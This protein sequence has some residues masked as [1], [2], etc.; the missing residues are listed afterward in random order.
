MERGPYAPPKSQVRDVVEVPAGGLVY[1][2][3]WRRFGAYW[4]DFLVLLP[5]MGIGYY[6]GEQSRLFQVYW[7]IPGL[8]IGLWFH[9][10]L[11]RRYGGTPGKLLLSTRIAM[12]DGS[13]VT[14]NAAALRYSVLFVLSTAAS[15]AI[16]LAALRMG[17]DEYFS[18]AYLARVQ[19][20]VELAP[21]WY[22]PVNILLQIWVWSEFVT[23][24]FN[25]KRRAIHDFMAGTVV[26]RTRRPERLPE[27]VPAHTGIA[28]SP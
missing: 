26:I 10:D 25:K 22:Q 16:L 5:L 9:V 2:G 17:D 8:L 28:P 18:L 27:R 24:L 21:T 12:T 20:M 19:R 13:P 4:I 6:F 3:F 1:A 11:V 14:A 15:L 23:M 7:F